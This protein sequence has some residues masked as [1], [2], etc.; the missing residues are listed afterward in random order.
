MGIQEALVA[1]TAEERNFVAMTARYPGN[2][3]AVG[4]QGKTADLFFPKRK[5]QGTSRHSAQ[6]V[7]GTGNPGSPLAAVERTTSH[8]LS[9]NLGPGGH[10]SVVAE[11]AIWVVKVMLASV[12]VWCCSQG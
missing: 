11:L 8:S 4:E 2:P 5:E 12:P 6:G 9:E 7:V 3:T 10:H 1:Q